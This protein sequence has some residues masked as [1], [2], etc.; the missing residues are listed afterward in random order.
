MKAF[1]VIVVFALACSSPAAPILGKSPSFRLTNQDGQAFTSNELAGK[2]H[3]VDFIFTTCRAV[4]PLLTARMKKLEASTRSTLPN[5]R[6]ISITVD[7]E[8]D[9]PAK[10]TTYAQAERLNLARFTLLTGSKTA[11]ERTVVGGYKQ[12]LGARVPLAADAN[13]FDIA[14]SMRFVV[15]DKQG[16]IRAFAESGEEHHG[17]IQSLLTQLERE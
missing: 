6:F 5:V 11:I 9:T 13:A 4:C 12:A 14:H 8:T 10:L 7:P 15:V 17:E 3:V 16:R 1:F 2:V